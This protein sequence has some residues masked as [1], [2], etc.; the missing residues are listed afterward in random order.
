[1]C[2]ICGVWGG[3]D[4]PAQTRSMLDRLAHRGPDGD[5]IWAEKDLTLGH[6]RLAIV[7]LTQ[8]GAQPMVTADGMHVAAVN[9]E[10]YN[11]PELRQALEKNGA[12]F[13][14]DCDSEVVLHA[15]RAQGLEALRQFNGMFAFALWD[16]AKQQL[17]LARDRLGI[18]PLYYHRGPNGFRFASEIKALLCGAEHWQIDGTGLAQFLTYQNLF[19]QQTLLDGIRM[20][21]PGHALIVT[22]EGARTVPF[23]EP[24]FGKDQS[25]S[26]FGAAVGQFSTT[27]GEAVDRHLMSDVP[28]ACYLSAGFDSASV[29][30]EAC[31]RLGPGV[32]TFTGSFDR[33]GWYDEYS[34]AQSVAEKLGAEGHRVPIDSAAFAARLDDV[35]HALDEPRMGMG[36]L[37]QFL[38]AEVAARERKVILTGHGGDELFSGYPIFKLAQLAANPASVARIRPSEL[39]HLAYFLMNAVRGGEFSACLPVLFSKRHQRQ[40]LQ[41]DIYEVV[42]EECARDPLDTLTSGARNHYERILLTYLRAYLPGLLTVEDKISMAHSLEARTPILDNKLVDLS[43]SI[44]PDTKLQGGNLKAILKEAMRPHLPAALYDMPKRGF[45]TPLGSWLR[46]PLSGFL[47]KRLTHPDSSLTRLFRHDYL[48]A[49]VDRYLA[50]EPLLRP[51]DE[52]PTHRMWMLL[53]LES[54]LRQGEAKWG[55]RFEAG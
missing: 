11:Y 29:A 15:Y 10:I 54:W 12:V 49:T 47:Q 7:D 3:R 30:A 55:V 16:K 22:A 31:R 50:K 38:V 2:G 14:S 36:A 37:P 48:K 26:D 9:G 24:S 6:N 53:G 28:V 32:A 4:G 33:G 27:F 13:A 17:I 51:L 44:A 18:K 21:E 1:M 52:I 43:L 19:G 25:I 5:G 39:P 35:I 20:L 42:R 41:P 46:G 34:G 23:W 40:A 8:A 45:P